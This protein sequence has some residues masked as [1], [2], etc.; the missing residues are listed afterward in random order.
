MGGVASGAAQGVAAISLYLGIGSIL[1]II[2]G[3][4]DPPDPID[5]TAINMNLTYVRNDLNSLSTTSTL[6]ITN[7]NNT[8]TSILGY[9]NG[10]TSFSTIHLNVS[11]STT[12]NN[13]ITLL[14]SLNVSGSTSLNNNTTLL[15]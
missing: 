14:S 3:G 4:G 2:T 5:V 8:T 7:L 10:Y 6:A 13:N 15:S 11:G 12:L 9:I 1:D